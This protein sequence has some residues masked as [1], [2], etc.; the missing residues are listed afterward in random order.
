MESDHLVEPLFA[1][2]LGNEKGRERPPCGQ[3]VPEGSLPL[4]LNGDALVVRRVAQHHAVLLGA[5]PVVVRL[6]PINQLTFMLEGEADS[7]L[8]QNVP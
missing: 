1:V 7:V 3:A 4:S 8:L 6:V 5:G 2:P